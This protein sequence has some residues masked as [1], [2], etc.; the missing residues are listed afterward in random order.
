MHSNCFWF[1][2]SELGY[3]IHR[4]D[5]EIMIELT[6]HRIS[7]SDQGTLGL[8]LVGGTMLYS[9]ELPWRDNRPNLSRIRRGAYRATPYQSNRF[10][11]VYRLID[12]PDRSDILIHAGNLAG[13]VNK[14]FLTNSSGCILLGMQTGTIKG[15]LA[16][17]Q[18]KQAVYELVKALAG[19]DIMLKIRGV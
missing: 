15:Q 18:S 4:L 16:I 8:L 14:G 1:G 19:A 10:G 13:D 7:T 9:L 17:L 2:G 5:V 11:G 3:D 12:V 6:L